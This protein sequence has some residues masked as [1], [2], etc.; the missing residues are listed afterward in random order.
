[1]LTRTSPKPPRSLWLLPRLLDPLLPRRV[2]E[3]LLL[4]DLRRE[5]DAGEGL[6]VVPREAEGEARDVEAED[7]S[8]TDTVAVG[9]LMVPSDLDEDRGTGGLLMLRRRSLL[10]T[11]RRRRSLKK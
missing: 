9:F 1:V 11:R 5:E 7:E 6:Y 8:L 4:S 10:K 3:L 2:N